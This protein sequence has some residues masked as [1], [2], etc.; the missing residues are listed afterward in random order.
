MNTNRL[1]AISNDLGFKDI[2]KRIEKIAENQNIKDCPLV[3]PLVGEFSSGKT[4]LI[5]ALTDSKALETATQPTTATIFEVHFG[6]SSSKAI[7]MDVNGDSKEINDISS[8]KN[9]EIGDSLVVT[10]FD[11]SDKVPS[12]IVLV[13]TPGLSSPDPRH[14]QTLVDFL[15][16]ADAVLLVADI[17]A[18]ITR[19]LLDFVETMSLTNKRLFLVLTKADTK[20]KTE[21]EASRKYIKDNM[22][23]S[24]E[25]IVCVSAKNDIGELLT[26][27][28]TIQK[29]KSQILLKVN[30][31][32]LRTIVNEMA[33]RI[34]ELLKTSD[35]DK[36]AEEQIAKKKLELARIQRKINNSIE[37]AGSDIQ[38]T[39]RD[40]S[41][42]FEDVI[43]ERLSTLVAGK[44]NDFDNEALSLIN[45][46]ASI[47]LSEYKDNVH[48]VLH[49]QASKSIGEDII[50]MSI[51]N[52]IDISSLSINGLSYNLNLNT[53]GHEYDGYI[54]TGVKIVAAAAA[55]AAAAG[56]ATAAAGSA[57]TTEAAGTAAITG[58][59]DASA[60]TIPTVISA[61]DT[62]TDVG[63]MIVTGKLI[64]RTKKAENITKKIGKKYEEIESAEDRINQKLKSKGIINSM[65]GFFT[66]QA[67]GK[68]QRR[69]AIHDYIDNTLMPQFNSQITQ[70]SNVI[71]ENVRQALSKSAENTITG[72]TEAINNL[73]KIRESQKAE[74]ENRISMLRNYKKELTTI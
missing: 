7:V 18:Q 72:L 29:D 27:F 19:S 57:A 51:L 11:T 40:S 12:S 35:N 6:A 14:R 62:A 63:S 10:V 2:S 71:I 41:R 68:P 50:D 33:M 39:L 25:N 45:N 24:D 26:L 53:L 49:N 55:V 32:R 34:D 46:T 60:A 67:M 3:L 5:N 61:A 44:S 23:I 13:D 70:I 31:Q 69:K 30:E 47:I 38:K 17:N 37:A 1:L 58:T 28:D 43:Y 56:A 52:N 74:Y 9:S 48:K 42:K 15:P 73:Q 4:T 36:G 54:S 65:V 20:S 22:H 66:D 8:L 59:A 21:I 16:E 64:A